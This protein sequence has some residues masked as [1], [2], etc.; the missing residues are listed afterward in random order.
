MIINEFANLYKFFHKT[1]ADE[2]AVVFYAEHAG[3]Y[4]YFEGIIKE[5]TESHNLT[6]TYIT[7]DS[8]DPVL[9]SPPKNL[10]PVFLKHTFFILMT[11]LDCKILVMTMTDLD[12]LHIKKSVNPVHYVYAFHSPLSTHMS[13]PPESFD[14]YDSI[15]C[16]GEYQLNEIRK[17]EVI[18]GLRPKN[19][20]EAG[21]YRLERINR[22]Y[23]ALKL[24]AKEPEKETT[25]LI[26]PSWGERNILSV[27]GMEL[28]ELLLKSGYKV[29]IRPHPE[30]MHKQKEILA[31]IK[32]KFDSCSA[33]YLEESISTDESLLKAD[34]MISNY[35]GVAIE[36]AL[37]TE[38]PVLFIDVPKKVK[39]PHYK[40]L[41]L[42][43]LELSIRDKIGI[44]L[45]SPLDSKGCPLPEA[46][47]NIAD[48]PR[49]INLLLE[50]SKEYAENIR[51]LRENTFFNFGSSSKAGADYILK[52]LNKSP[53][54][55]TENISKENLSNESQF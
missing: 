10:K 31:K 42:D 54:Y 36:Y 5:L 3:Y 12:N 33:F 53:I 9:Q 25:V 50:K 15:L 18:Q 43:P 40:I 14:H 17:R 13:Y 48:V 27:Y 55:Q 30:T 11:M 29:V 39:N 51:T 34:I 23:E 52:L 16:T 28:T 8:K 1:P 41:E 4:P 38:R 26:A 24:N 45:P 22:A 21:Y 44:V 32:H 20:I 6:V 47:K 46:R 35:S 49:H 37:G 2:K 19:L 7:S